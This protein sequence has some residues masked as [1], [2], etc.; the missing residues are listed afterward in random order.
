MESYNPNAAA[1]MAEI[2]K[3]YQKLYVPSCNIERKKTILTK[4][5]VHGDQLFEER[6]RNVQWTF[7]DGA[8][9]SCQNMPTGMPK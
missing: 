5:P 9:D 4:V 8:N 2:L 1:E 6:A 3:D 7:R